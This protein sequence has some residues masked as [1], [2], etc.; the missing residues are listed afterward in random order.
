VCHALV[1][2]ALDAVQ[3]GEHRTNRLVTQR[4]KRFVQMHN[5]PNSAC[6]F[7]SIALE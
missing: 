3:A 2:R 4:N 1:W 5:S 6:Y 7:A